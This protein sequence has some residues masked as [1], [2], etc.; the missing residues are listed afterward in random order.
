VKIEKKQSAVNGGT[1]AHKFTV[2]KIETKKEDMFYRLFHS[3]SNKAPHMVYAL[4]KEIL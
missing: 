4:L 2:E 1:Q 3:V